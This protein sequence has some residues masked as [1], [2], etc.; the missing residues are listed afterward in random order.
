MPETVITDRGY[1]LV[2]PDSSADTVNIS[3]CAD[4]DGGEPTHAFAWHRQVA[5]SALTIAPGVDLSSGSTGQ[6]STDVI[7]VASV[8]GAVN[9]RQVP[10][11]PYSPAG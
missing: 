8:D 2:E 11:T 1:V 4:S 7:E 6:Y 5:N 10:A 3:I 9:I